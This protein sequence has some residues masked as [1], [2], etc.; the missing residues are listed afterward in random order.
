MRPPRGAA[1]AQWVTAAS[2]AWVIALDNLSHVTDWLSDSLCRAVTG[3][4][5]VRRALYTDND[6]HVIAFKRC[7]ILNGIDLGAVR[8]G[9]RPSSPTGA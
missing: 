8:G 5:N 9:A 1:E 4:A 3:D 6:T 2:G 7:L